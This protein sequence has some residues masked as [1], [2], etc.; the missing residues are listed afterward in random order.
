MFVVVGYVYIGA[1]LRPSI[2]IKKPISKVLWAG[3]SELGTSLETGTCVELSEVDFKIKFI[4]PLCQRGEGVV[5]RD[6]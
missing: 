1:W 2:L 3:K 4:D 5:K 6:T